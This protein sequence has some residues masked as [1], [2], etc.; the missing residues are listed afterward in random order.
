MCSAKSIHYNCTLQLTVQNLD[1]RMT[2]RSQNKSKSGK[3]TN[4]IFGH[5]SQN[6]QVSKRKENVNTYISIS[7][8][9]KACK[10]CTT[11][12]IYA[13]AMCF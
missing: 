11:K 9:I 4:Q 3:K 8:I 1:E 7:Y 5:D 13:V 12:K 10:N 2:L 6:I